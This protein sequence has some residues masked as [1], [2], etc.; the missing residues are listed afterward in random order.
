MCFK[1][2]I[3]YTDFVAYK[4]EHIRMSEHMYTNYRNMTKE[5]VSM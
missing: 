2:F 3:I 5:I 4:N 1:I